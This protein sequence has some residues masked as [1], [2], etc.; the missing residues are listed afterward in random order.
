MHV[1]PSPAAHAFRADG[2]EEPA[3]LLVI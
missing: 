3:F 1:M 2:G